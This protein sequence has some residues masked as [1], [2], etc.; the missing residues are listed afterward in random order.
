M[1]PDDLSKIMSRHLPQEAHKIIP[2]AVSEPSQH[3]PTRGIE[4]SDG[5]PRMIFSST[6]PQVSGLIR[7]V[8]DLGGHRRRTSRP[9]SRVL[10]RRGVDLRRSSR[11]WL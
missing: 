1:S 10:L 9:V 6:F 8:A 11:S 4:V 2:W 3:G 7:A 5:H